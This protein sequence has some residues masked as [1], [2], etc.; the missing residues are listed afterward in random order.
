MQRGAT[1]RCSRWRPAG[2]TP[3]S[4]LPAPMAAMFSLSLTDLNPAAASEGV[5]PKPPVCRPVVVTP[6]SQYAP[7]LAQSAGVPN[8]LPGGSP[9]RFRPVNRTASARH[10]GRGYNT[11]ET[12][13][14][15]QHA[16]VGPRPGGRL[17]LQPCSQGDRDRGNRR[18]LVEPGTPSRPSRRPGLHSCDVPLADEVIW[19]APYYSNPDDRPSRL[20]GLSLQ[21]FQPIAQSCVHGFPVF[22]LH[23]PVLPPS[24][25]PQCDVPASFHLPE[26][27]DR[28]ASR[29][30]P[31]R[32][33]SAII[34]SGVRA[35]ATISSRRKSGPA[36]RVACA[37]VGSQGIRS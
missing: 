24:K 1:V 7:A 3:D 21:P 11:A 10:V 22:E 5:L 31:G 32:I 13:D 14:R 17:D 26:D 16:S 15:T 4:L 2:K 37:H 8:R 36:M 34:S 9:V 19:Q 30:Y 6:R 28:S 23:C 12:A 29:S 20:P 27:F 35:N 25:F 18:A 33:G